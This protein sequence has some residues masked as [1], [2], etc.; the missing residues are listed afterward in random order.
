[1]EDFFL[2]LAKKFTGPFGYLILGICAFFENVIPPIPGDTVTVFG[3]YLAGTGKLSMAGVVI[4]T[5]LGSFF[6][7]MCMFFL[8]RVLGKKFFFE[9]KTSFF[10]HEGFLK[11]TGWFERFGYTVV[12][13]NRFL[14]GVRSVIS[15]A[16][17]ITKMHPAKVALLSFISC[18]VWNWLLIFAGCKVGEN[19]GLVLELLKKYNAGVLCV[20]AACALIWA[21]RKFFQGKKK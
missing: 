7:F 5:T 1:M 8:G 19:W 2:N 12:L 4:A 21:A 14:S 15:L 17:G 20:L 11:A 6:G 13:G 16:A 3:G 18:L 10:S 9:G